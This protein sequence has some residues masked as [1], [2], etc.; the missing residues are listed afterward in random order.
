MDP[1]AKCRVRTWRMP[2]PG[3]FQGPTA[4]QRLKVWSMARATAWLHTIDMQRDRHLGRCR[5]C[6]QRVAT[7]TDHWFGRLMTHNLADYHSPVSADEHAIDI[8]FIEEKD[9]ETNPL[10]IK[11]VGEIGIV[12]S[13]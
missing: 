1:D 3:E 7:A 2:L 10:S 4:G 9:D 8:I 12:G 6:R 13:A 11:G 5:T